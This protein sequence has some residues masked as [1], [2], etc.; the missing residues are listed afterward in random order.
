MAIKSKRGAGRGRR[1]AFNLLG[2]DCRKNSTL[3]E[4][5]LDLDRRR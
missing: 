3:T 5:S 4:N 1:P 2:L